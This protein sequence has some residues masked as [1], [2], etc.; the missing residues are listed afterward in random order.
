MLSK[1]FPVLVEI[2]TTDWLVHY[3]RIAFADNLSE[4]GKGVVFAK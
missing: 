4:I 1:I 3:D 2:D